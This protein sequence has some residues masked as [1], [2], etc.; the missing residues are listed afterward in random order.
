VGPPSYDFRTFAATGLVPTGTVAGVGADTIVFSLK[1]L[2]S[3]ASGGYTFWAADSGGASPVKLTGNI[4]E[5]FLRDS[6][7]AGGNPVNDPLTDEVIR[8]RDTNFV[9]GV[10]TYAGPTVGSIV[11]VDARMAATGAT[12]L[13]SAVVSLDPSGSDQFLWFR[14]E[15]EGT[16][17]TAALT[18]TANPANGETVTIG[19]KVYTFETTLTD[20][21]GHV[22]IGATNAASATNLR[23]AIVL[24]AGSGTSYAA[25]TTVHPSVTATVATNV[26]TVTTKTVGAHRNITLAETLASGAWGGGATFMQGGGNGTMFFGNFGGPAG[27]RTLVTDTIVSPADDDFVFTVVSSRLV[28]GIRGDEIAVELQGLGRPPV[29]FAYHGYLVDDAGAGTLVDVLHSTYPER[30]DLT[31][32]DTDDTHTVI[33]FDPRKD[34]V[35]APAQIRN[36]VTGA[37]V[38]NATCTLNL[39]LSG[40]SSAFRGF[41]SFVVTLDPKTAD[42]GVLGPNVVWTAPIPAI[43]RKGTGSYQ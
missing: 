43:V 35:V 3:L 9:A 31:D 17:A 33:G 25:A 34:Q 13:N 7:D 42:A 30:A 6:L 1:N 32:V 19:G 12:G 37:N 26:V 20:V 28:G 22:L 2:A 8:V 4:V 5:I 11:Q 15:V 41:A 38:N 18:L 21:D 16:S 24:A 39:E 14:R 27:Q 36:C 40:D 23:S 10:D 29:G